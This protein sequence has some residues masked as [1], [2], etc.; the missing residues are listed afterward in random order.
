[1][2]N[3]VQPYRWKP[4]RLPCPWDSPSRNTGVGCHFLLQ[5][6]KVKSESEDAQ[7]C[8]SLSDSMDCSLPGSSVH[9]I[10]QARVLEW[11]AIAF[12]ALMA[13]S[14]HWFSFSF[15]LHIYTLSQFFWF[16]FKNISRISSLLLCSSLL[17][18]SSHPSLFDRLA[19]AIGFFASILALYN[20]LSCA[21]IHVLLKIWDTVIYLLRIFQDLPMPFIGKCRFL[22][23]LTVWSFLCSDIMISRHFHSKLLGSSY[24]KL[25]PAVVCTL[26]CFLC[27]GHSYPSIWRFDIH[28][29]FKT[30]QISF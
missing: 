7:L 21:K 25:I 12:S 2:S 5:C 1:M 9:G 18:Y 30:V 22:V 28:Q 11:G 24:T 19:G 20:Q 14:H 23:W 8:P 10:F 4:T 27:L 13:R 15:T 6:M 16:S 3:S 17:S 29:S 26:C